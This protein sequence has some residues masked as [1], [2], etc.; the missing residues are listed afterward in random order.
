M[1]K[2][3]ISKLPPPNIVP[4]LSYDALLSDIKADHIAI[5]P[6]IE[7]ALDLRSE[8]VSKQLEGLAGRE[9]KVRALYNDNARQ[10]LLAFANGTN[11]DAIAANYG[12]MRL[13][14]ETD[15]RFRK[16]IQIAPNSWSVAGP[17]DAYIFWALTADVN[18]TDVEVTSPAGAEVLIKI[19][20]QTGDPSAFVISEVATTLNA[21]TLRPVG[22]RITVAPCVRDAFNQALNLTL[23]SG[24]DQSKVISAA[25]AAVRKYCAEERR[26]G[27]KITKSKF[28]G[29]ATA[30]EG[31]ADGAA[32]NMADY[33][34]SGAGHAPELGALTINIV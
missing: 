29:V 22:D 8:P 28:V 21:K 24:V 10:S 32:P 4:E 5:N 11:L 6:G 13:D 18:I 34:G 25:E 30:I 33:I 17:A 23:K 16:R 2:I 20:M 27:G 3:D 19:L 14:D 7:A 15:E 1:S 26:I 9:L 12:V 31:V